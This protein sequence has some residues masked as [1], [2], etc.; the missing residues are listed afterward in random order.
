MNSSVAI[1][2]ELHLQTQHSDQTNE[3]RSKVMQAVDCV[4]RHRIFQPQVAIILG[5]GLGGLAED[6]QHPSHVPYEEIPHFQATHAAGHRG[7]LVLGYLAGMPVV[8]MQGRY[9]RYEG[10]C[11]ADVC[12][13]VRVMRALGATTLLVTNAAG[14]LNPRYRP[15]DLMIVDQ[16]IDCLWPRG[17]NARMHGARG[18]GQIR[19]DKGHYDE[20]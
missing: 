11:H 10:H 4:S 20:G 8:I 3:L 7:R 5:S 6:V 17:Q 2:S 19:G 9:H 1:P 12:F 16:H 15:G 18:P 13:P 14:G